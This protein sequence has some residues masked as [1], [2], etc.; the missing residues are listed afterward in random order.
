MCLHFFFQSSPCPTCL[1]CSSTPDSDERIVIRPDRELEC[2]HLVEREAATLFKFFCLA[3]P[4][5]ALCLLSQF[6]K[7][8]SPLQRLHE[9]HVLFSVNTELEIPNF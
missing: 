2:L 3:I 1:F 6:L 7:L 9:I 5:G 4:K 8:S